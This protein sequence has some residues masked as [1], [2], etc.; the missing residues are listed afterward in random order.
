MQT[1]IRMGGLCL[2]VTVVSGPVPSIRRVVYGSR[3]ST[4][5]TNTDPKGFAPLSGPGTGR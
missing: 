1:L 3:F 5:A 2:R 4:T